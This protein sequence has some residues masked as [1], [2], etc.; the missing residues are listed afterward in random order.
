MMGKI[1]IF[2]SMLIDI[3]INIQDNDKNYEE[4]TIKTTKCIKSLTKYSDYRNIFL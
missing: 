3:V 4:T 2:F 1:I